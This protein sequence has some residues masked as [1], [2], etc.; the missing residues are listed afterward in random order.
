MKKKKTIWEIK[1]SFYTVKKKE[2]NA[3]KRKKLKIL[4][5]NKKNLWI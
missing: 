4:N 2:K 3:K 1:I 5:F